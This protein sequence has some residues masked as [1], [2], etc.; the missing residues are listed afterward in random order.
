MELDDMKLAWQT[1]DRRLDLQNALQVY[2][3]KQDQL[4]KTRARLRRLYWG[5][6]VQILFGDA[7]ILFGIFAVMRYHND[8]QL[9]A[10]ALCVLLYGALIVVFGG[11]TLGKISGIDY[12][13]PVVDIQKQ[14]GALR[15]IHVFTSL[16]AGL[17]WWFLWIP[18]FVL[19]VKA[20]L[21]VNLFDNAP[22][23]I[24]IS[25]AVGVAGLAATWWI[26]RVSGRPANARWRTALERTFTAR[27]LRE[28][29]GELDEIARFENM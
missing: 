26:H 23:F 22:E 17:P 8:M 1:L 13:A 21:G 18:I 24:W 15:R 4:D 7:L 2:Q 29:K 16:C 12:A 10:C 5:K 14:V 20:N 19:E 6:I 11:V 25:V 28:A 3:F 9:F 27:S